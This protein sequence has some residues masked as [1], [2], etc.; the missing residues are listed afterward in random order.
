MNE[1][2]IKVK[3]LTK[4][5]GKTIAL[6][7]V[8]LEIREGITGLV[9][10]NG[11]GKTTLINLII[12]LI[13]K[14]SGRIIIRTGSKDFRE[15]IGVIRDI[16]A[17]P[18]ELEVEYFLEKIAGIY[19]VDKRNVAKVIELVG[20]KEVRYKRIG[21]LSMGYKKRLGIAHAVVQRPILIIA[22]EPFTGLDPI[23]KVDIRDTFARLNKDEGINFFISSHNIGDL[24][25]IA[26]EV[27]LINKGRIIRTLRKGERLSVIINV[28]NSE[29]FY[30]Y[31]IKR[32][33]VTHFNGTHVRVDVENMKKL[34]KVLYEYDGE[35]F[36]INMA[37]IEGVIRDEVA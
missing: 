23:I 21:S 13:E 6:K 33:F 34:F 7:N 26:D 36:G 11:A 35:I 19:G 28:D 32:G 17:F 14:D 16:M 3:N 2:L 1:T 10:P 5:Y 18:K 9:G 15:D 24:E 31:M 22:D 8:S 37:S 30:E 20:L 29:K 12:G 27:I 25:M 4:R